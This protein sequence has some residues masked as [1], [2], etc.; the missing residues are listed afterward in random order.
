MSVGP[1]NF[2]EF[3]GGNLM[4]Y[5]YQNELLLNTRLDV[6]DSALGDLIA[7]YEPK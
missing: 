5:G 2:A 4:P 3:V 7:R 1:S 6:A